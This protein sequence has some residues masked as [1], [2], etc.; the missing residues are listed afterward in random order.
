VN[1]PLLA[2]T[3]ALVS[4]LALA[5]AT[6]APDRAAHQ[7]QMRQRAEARFAEADKNRDGRISL[8]EFQDASD[9]RLAERFARM[10]ANKDGQLTAEEMRSAREARRGR[11]AG[12]RQAM[13][14]HMEKLRALDANHDQAL[15]RA[16]IGTAMPMLVEHFDQLDTDHDGRLTRDEM[17]AGHEA[18][19]A[20]HAR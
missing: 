20:Q 7:A 16:E 19:R 13:R 18:M 14:G 17:R 15:T 12:H 11:M 6:V 9:R 5:Q 3:L 8:A 1:K 4:G 10:D 2:L